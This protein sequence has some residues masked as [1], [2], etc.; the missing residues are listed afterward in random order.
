MYSVTISSRVS[1]SEAA[2]HETFFVITNAYGR[3]SGLGKVE[4]QANTLASSLVLLLI[5]REN[6]KTDG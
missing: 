3:S 4:K 2:A 5:G 6:R 1:G